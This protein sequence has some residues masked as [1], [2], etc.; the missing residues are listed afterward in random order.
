MKYVLPTRNIHSI[1]LPPKQDKQEDTKVLLEKI[2]NS[3]YVKY[4]EEKCT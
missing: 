1:T 2:S 4:Y 3:S